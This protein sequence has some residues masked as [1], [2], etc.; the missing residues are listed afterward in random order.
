MTVTLSVATCP[1]P[2]GPLALATGP[3]GLV[4]LELGGDRTRVEADLRRRFEGC[5]LREARDPGGVVTAL[6]RYFD[7]RLDALNGLPVDPGGTAF[8]RQVWLTLREIPAG[9]TWSYAQLARAVGRPSAVRAVGATNG[10]NPLPLVLPCHRV[11]GADGSL[12]GYG[13]GLDRKVWL[14]RHEGAAW[15]GERQASL[16]LA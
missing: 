12:V 7:G 13:G 16:D 11:I 9:Q 2:I 6:R 1:S 15:R 3:A 10:R 4:R 5:E 14:L 8:Q